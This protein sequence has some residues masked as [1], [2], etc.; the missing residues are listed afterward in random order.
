MHAYCALVKA[1]Y[2]PRSLILIPE[3][4]LDSLGIKGE[5][6][7][8][9]A[10]PAAESRAAPAASSE[11]G[12]MTG[13]TAS[14]VPHTELNPPTPLAT[15]STTSGPDYVEFDGGYLVHQVRCN[16]VTVQ[17]F[18]RQSIQIIADCAGR[19]FLSVLFRCI[20]LRTR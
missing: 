4:P 19:Q 12:P 17:H 2:P 7:T 11:S 20:G 13:L 8:V 14:Q 1:G 18:D 6:L 16:V 5:Q 15:P 10:K 9:N 3:L